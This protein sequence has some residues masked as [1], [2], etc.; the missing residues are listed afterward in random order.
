MFVISFIVVGCLNIYKKKDGDDLLEKLLPDYIYKAICNINYDGL[1]EI[2]LRTN[3]PVIVN[4]MGCYYYLNDYGITN[5]YNNLIY[6]KQGVIA[7]ILKC[8]SNNSLYSINDQLIKGYINYSAGVRIGVS[9]EVVS[10][11]G[12]IST[13]KNISSLNIR[14]PHNIKNCS[15]NVYPF[16]LNNNRIRSTLIISSP[17][18][19]KTTFLR[20]LICQISS[21]NSNE[22]VLVIDERGEISGNNMIRLGDNVDV[23]LNSTKQFGFSNGIRSLSPTVIAVDELNL[24]NDLDAIEQALTSGVSIIATIHAKNINELKQKKLFANVLKMGVFERFI[25]LN[26]VSRPGTLEGVYNQNFDCIYY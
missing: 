13:I 9:G 23:I 16:L 8:V 15:L 1:N 21:K 6:C 2:K 10:E 18:A 3:R 22:C 4:I 24:L 20:D 14:I 17:G 5:N 26:G 7:E 12:N 25:V 19:G 11:R